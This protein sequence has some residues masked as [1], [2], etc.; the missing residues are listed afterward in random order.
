[1]VLKRRCAHRPGR[2][3]QRAPFPLCQGAKTSWELG[4]AVRRQLHRLVETT[5][6]S[7]REDKS[8]M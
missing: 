6:E 5:E 1:M 4:A 3:A 7:N 2:W 8:T